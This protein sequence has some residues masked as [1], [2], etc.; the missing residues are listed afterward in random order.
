MAVARDRSSPWD[1]LR[2]CLWEPAGDGLLAAQSCGEAVWHQAVFSR[3]LGAS[4]RH[5]DAEQYEVSKAKM[6]TIESKH[7]NL[8]TRITRLIH[9]TL[10]FSTTQCMYDLVMRCFSNR[11]AC[12]PSL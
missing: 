11:Y 12:G 6:Q 4:E 7:S 5:L 8:W 2:V 1:S 9:R 10:C 3:G